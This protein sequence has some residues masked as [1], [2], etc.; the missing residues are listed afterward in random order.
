[1]KGGKAM[2]VFSIRPKKKTVLA[3]LAVIIIAASLFI[4]LAAGKNASASAKPQNEVFL[5]TNEERREFLRRFGWETSE[6]P[7]E[8]AAVTI[9]AEFNDVYE[10]YNEI[11]KAQGFNL[12]PLKG[13]PAKRFTYQVKNYPNVS[14]EV[15]AD[16]LISDGRLIGGDVMTTRMDGFMHGFAL[17]KKLENKEE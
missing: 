10:S 14:D 1:M 7:I 6:E 13:K 17:P 4:V 12:E 2:F 8:I 11:Q 5:N 16:L 9:P 15:R 3:V